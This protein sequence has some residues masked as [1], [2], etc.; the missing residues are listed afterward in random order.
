VNEVV[1]SRMSAQDAVYQMQRIAFFEREKWLAQ[2]PLWNYRKRYVLWLFF[3]ETVREGNYFIYRFPAALVRCTKSPQ[4]FE[5][6][7]SV[8]LSAIVTQVRVKIG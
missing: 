5:E 1:Y 3:P 8:G 2:F 4:T 7:A 6:A